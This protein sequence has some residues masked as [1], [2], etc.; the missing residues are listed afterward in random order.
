[1]GDAVVASLAAKAKPGIDVVF[2]DTGYHFVETIGMRDAVAAVYDV[3]VITVNAGAH[4][5][6]S[7]T[8]R[9]G[10]ELYRPRS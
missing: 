5:S 7:K 3:N 1:M 2:L 6:P 8:P 10:K 4:A 9:Y